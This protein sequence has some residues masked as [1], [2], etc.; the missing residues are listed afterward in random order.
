MADVRSVDEQSLVEAKRIIEHGGVIVLPTDTVYGI[1][2]DP[3]NPNAIARIYEAKKRARS[4]ALQIIVS[5]VNDLPSLG[6]TLPSPLDVL[7]QRFLPGA[8]SPIAVAD[9]NCALQTLRV[10]D[11]GT[12]T[13]AIRVPDSDASLRILRAIGPVAASSANRS[14]NESAQTVDEAVAA[15]GDDVDLYLDAGPTENHTA[16]TVVAADPDAPD[17]IVIL[18]EGKIPTTQLRAAMHDSANPPHDGGLAR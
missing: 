11:D 17:G 18:R 6:L 15:F 10:T 5:S 1:A 8:F 7:A 12:R 9:E 2:C 3:R 16:S 4:K 13:Q 14:G